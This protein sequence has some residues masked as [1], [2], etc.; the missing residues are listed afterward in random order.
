LFFNYVSISP[1]TGDELEKN[2]KNL[3]YQ[4]FSKVP[5]G[6]I[7]LLIDKIK[8]WNEA[9]FYINQTVEN[10][11]SRDVLAL[12]IKSGLFKRSGKAVFRPLRK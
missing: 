6:H 3:F 7:K 12:Q 9:L 2:D 10:G 1:R 11:W 4:T 5:W 8:D